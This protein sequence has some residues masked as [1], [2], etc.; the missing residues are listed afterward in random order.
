ML[1][2][3]KGAGKR[4]HKPSNATASA[5]KTQAAAAPPAGDAGQGTYAA[6]SSGPVDSVAEIAAALA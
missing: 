2:L 3:P 4:V 5:A 1:Y 6:S